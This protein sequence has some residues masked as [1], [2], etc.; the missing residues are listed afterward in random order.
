VFGRV[1]TGSDVPVWER[2]MMGGNRYGIYS[3]HQ[4]PFAG[5]T[6]AEFMEN[7][8]FGAGLR[9]QQRLGNIGYILLKGH[10]ADH[11]EK[12]SDLLKGK[13][14]WGTQV[15]YYYNSLIG[16]VGAYV[17]WSNYTKGIAAGINIGYEF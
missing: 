3:E 10:V 13:P 16:P 2:N 11:G 5:F 7:K 9:L 1:I 14:I 6:Y 17:S 8:L 12:F 15:A 4:I